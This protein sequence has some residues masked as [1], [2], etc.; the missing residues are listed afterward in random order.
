MYLFNSHKLYKS[1]LRH[2]VPLQKY[3]TAILK[4]HLPQY[5]A[6]HNLSRA[7]G[8]SQQPPPTALPVESTKRVRT[9][10]LYKR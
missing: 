4:L 5:Y 9:Q 10:D 3:N 2:P 1:I 7:V 8:G 6:V